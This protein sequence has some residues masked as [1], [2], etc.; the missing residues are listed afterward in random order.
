MPTKSQLVFTARSQVLVRDRK[1]RSVWKVVEK[2]MRLPAG[3][4]ALLLCDV[5]DKHTQRGAEERL[6]AMVPRMNRVVNACRKKGVLIIHSPSDTIDFYAQHPARKHV[7]DTKKRKPRE[8]RHDDPPLPFPKESTATDT[9]TIDTWK[10]SAGYPWT[11]EHKGITLRDEDAISADGVEVYSLMKAEG[12]E[13]LLIMGVHTNCCILHRTFAIKQMTRWG[14]DVYLVRD[15]TD[16]IYDPAKPPYVS[17][18]E[19][20]A[21]V[22]GY[23]EKF[24]CPTLASH[25]LLQ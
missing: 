22:V 3:R 12:V 13:H 15:L 18:D 24:W 4:T 10:E 17:H 25:D 14:V 23:I 5:W 16:G 8:R 1:R 6:G 2:R 11:R 20:T 7:L 21:L 19:G 9:P